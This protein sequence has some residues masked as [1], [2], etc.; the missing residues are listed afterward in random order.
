MIGPGPAH[1]PCATLVLENDR[2]RLVVVPALGARVVSLVDRATS[3]EWLVQGEPPA[4]PDAW[5]SP[6]AVFSGPASYGWDECLPTVAPCPDPLDPAAPALRDHGDA[7]GRPAASA[8]EGGVLV[9][10]WTGIRWPFTLRRELRVD[11]PVVRADY[12]LENRGPVEL[13]FLWSMHPLFAIEPG[14]RIEVNDLR[15]VL[16]THAAGIDL[17]FLPRRVPWP[18]ATDDRGE[19]IAW[20]TVRARE[21]GT[22]AKLYGGQ[23]AG[24]EEWLPGLSAMTVPDGSR[25]ELSW[26]SLPVPAVGIWLDDGGWPTSA[27]QVQ[28]ALEP[29]TSPDDDL[30]SAVAAG[31]AML[32]APGERVAWEAMLRVRHPLEARD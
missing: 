32:A 22:A 1:G 3:R 13:P 15:S 18:T 11:G 5:S 27:G 8:A 31:R 12:V 25:L 28:H 17:P 26:C 10:T 23:D 19:P 16:V 4:A 30:V 14:S 24:A 6:D 20:D 21:A 9:A 7:W 29:T 2:L